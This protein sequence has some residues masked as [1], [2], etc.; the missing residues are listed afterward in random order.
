MKLYDG[1]KLYHGSYCPIET[2]D[3]SKCSLTKDFGQGFYLTTDQN[4]AM[5][6]IKSSLFKAKQEKL[7]PEDQT[8]GYVTS[9]IYRE[10]VKTSLYEFSTANKEWLWYVASNRRGN[11][12]EDMKTVI[13]SAIYQADIIIGK[14]ANDTTNRVLAAYLNGLFGDITSETAIN[15]ALDQLLPE[16]LS[17]QLCFK[18][19]KAVMCLTRTEVERYD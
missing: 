6:F 17:D 2:I 3:L 18:S 4:Q 16:K 14:I 9:F 11:I 8:T 1:I 7:I 5:K 12:S 15:I 13:D 19:E 10:N